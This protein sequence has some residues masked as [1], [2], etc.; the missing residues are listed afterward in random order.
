MYKYFIFLIIFLIYFNS[1]S[2][3]SSGIEK[4]GDVVQVLI[5]SAAILG[6]WYLSD[7]DGLIQFYKS[8]AVNLGI[9]YGLKYS[10]DKKR[11]DGKSK[12]FPSG[13]TSAAFQSAAF[14]HKRYGIEYGVP[15]YLAA[16]FVGYSRVESDRHY[17]E[18]VIAGAVIGTASSFYFTKS[19]KHPIITPI[20]S[21]KKYGLFI[22]KYW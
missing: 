14:I 8:F 19:Y 4:S 17:W 21:N 12:S 3:A 6:I 2:M 11:P 10:I 5:P 22:T 20:V 15:A 1:V 9:T 16:S 18:D 13:H 7:Y